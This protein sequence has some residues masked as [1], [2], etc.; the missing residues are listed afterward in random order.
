MAPLFCRNSYLD[1][2]VTLPMHYRSL[3]AS[4]CTRVDLLEKLDGLHSEPMR[5]ARHRVHVELGKKE[6]NSVQ[7]C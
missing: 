6:E 5:T 4:W 3:T 7:G 1:S 2:I